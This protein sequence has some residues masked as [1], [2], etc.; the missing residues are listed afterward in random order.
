MSSSTC[1]TLLHRS[2]CHRFDLCPK[3]FYIF[4][5]VCPK[6]NWQIKKDWKKEIIRRK[7]KSTKLQNKSESINHRL[8]GE[9]TVFLWVEYL[10]RARQK[11]QLKE[12]KIILSKHRIRIDLY[13]RNHGS[14]QTRLNGN[15]R[16]YIFSAFILNI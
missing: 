7:K 10:K 12:K 6:T 15:L 4:L 1:I 2:V 13:K 14:S 11:L 9:Q 16:S 5:S 3:Q 8:D